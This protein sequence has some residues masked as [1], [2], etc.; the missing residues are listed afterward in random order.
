ME[1]RWKRHPDNPVLALRPGRFD[2]NHIHAPMVFRDR[3][4]F[5][6]LYSGSDRRGN[7]YHRI[8]YAESEDGIEWR[9][10]PSPVLS[11]ESRDGYYTC[12]TLLRDVEG[13]VMREGGLYRMWFCG[14]PD[15]LRLHHATSPDAINWHIDPQ[16]PLELDA[17]SPTV[18]HEAGAYRMW[19]TSVS[20]DKAMEIG[21]AESRDGID[22]RVESES[23]LRSTED[24]EQKN[25]LYPFVIKRGGRYEMYYT[26]Y[27]RI[28]E[29]AVATSSDGLIWSKTGGPV[30]SPDPESDWDS[31]YCSR[32]CVV[33][34]P[35]GRDRLYYASRI[36]MKHKY[37]AIGLA[38]EIGTHSRTRRRTEM[39]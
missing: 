27:G 32:P 19:Y 26:S 8:G 16:D 20:E 21:L 14:R 13:A 35:G 37:F 4:I 24:W 18:I 22:W 36:D 23:V 25:L 12:P 34:V 15:D 38:E 11:P 33:T 30:L 7:R 6:M 17:Y 29:I 39:D 5:R 28:C 3:G 31:L 2:S 1:N 9:R 10:R